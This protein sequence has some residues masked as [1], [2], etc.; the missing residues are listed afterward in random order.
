MKRR[1]IVFQTRRDLLNTRGIRLE[2][3]DIPSIL[4]LIDLSHEHV[5]EA[6]TRYIFY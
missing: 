5:I 4:N 3:A 1:V 2:I 6:K